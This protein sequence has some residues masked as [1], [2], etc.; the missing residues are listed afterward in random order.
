MLARMLIRSAL[1]ALAGVIGAFPVATVVAA[2][3]PGPGQVYSWGTNGFG[4]L[5]FDPSLGATGVTPFAVPTLTTGLGVAAGGDH[6]LAVLAGGA[7]QAWGRNV[8]GELGRGSTSTGSNPTPA[9]VSGIGGGG[10]GGIFCNA[11]PT[12]CAVAVSA[13]F[14]FSVALMN[15]GTVRVWGNNGR[16]ELGNGSTAPNSPT[17]VDATGITTAT[18]IASGHGHNLALLSSGGVSA[19]GYNGCGALGVGN[20]NNSHVPVAVSGISTATAIAAG[21]C[22]SI[23]RLTNGKLM[24]WGDNFSGQLGD[25]TTAERTLPVEVK[26]IT[27]AVSVA[28]GS[29]HSLALLS[30]GTVRAWGSNGN[31]QLGIG[32]SGGF[33]NRPLEVEGLS[34]VAAVAAGGSTSYAIKSDG[35]LW[36]WGDNAA[37]QLGIG[38]SDMDPHPVPVQVTALGN[39]VVTIANAPSGNFNGAFGHILAVA[40][41]IA[42]ATPAT[43]TFGVH[44]PGTTSPPQTVTVRNSGAATMTVSGVE[45]T[46]ANASEFTAQAGDCLGQ[47]LAH[48]AACAIQVAFKPGATGVRTATLEVA[49][50]ALASPKTV[51]LAGGVSQTDGGTD[52]GTDGE[53]PAFAS[54]SMRRRFAV[55]LRGPVETPVASARRRRAPRGTKF[56]Y[57]VTEASRVVF[58]IQRK[59]PGRRVRGKC[60]KPTRKNR[61]RRRC[62]RHVLFGRFAQQAAAGA[63]TKAW[64]GR[65]GRKRLR[66]GRYRATLVATDQAGNASVPKRLRFT[67]VRR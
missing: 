13:G 34:D 65:L 43:M 11:F 42:D 59:R 33:A 12:R 22:H 10:R 23:A 19:W 17:P 66:P 56:A 29:A 63:N 49:H 62:T 46:G 41:A 14:N 39:G 1:P 2:P 38:T 51:P 58:T 44:A 30:D 35:T 21:G 8:S 4:K 26:D 53:A 60:V 32:D 45:I 40:R 18:A 64:S 31:G 16:G 25:S 55:N 48:D 37:G 20:K 47:A 54:A 28:G 15:N 6:S 50:D 5:G 67:V 36:A 3:P 7:V 57:T 52:G 9:P 24:A 27:T 61:N